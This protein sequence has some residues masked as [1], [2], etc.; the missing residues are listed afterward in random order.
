M[1]LLVFLF[2]SL[3]LCFS[4]G[5]VFYVEPSVP[6]SDSESPCD[7]YSPCHSLQYYANHSSFTTNNSKFLFLKG[8]HHLDTGVEIRYVANLSLVGTDRS[9]VKILCTSH[10]SGFH[11]EEF[12]MLTI[13]NISIQNCCVPGFCVPGFS[14]LS[15]LYL[16]NG[17][18]AI[19]DSVTVS[20]TPCIGLAAEDVVG[21]FVITNSIFN[22]EGLVRIKYGQCFQSSYLNFSNNELGCTGHCFPMTFWMGCYDVQILIT[23]SV[24]NSQSRLDVSGVMNNNSVLISNCI[25]RAPVS[26]EAHPSFVDK[27]RC[28]THPFFTFQ[29]AIVS[30]TLD[31]SSYAPM[32]NNVDPLLCKVLLVDSSQFQSISLSNDNTGRIEDMYVFRNVSGVNMTGP[33]L[34]LKN[35]AASLANCTFENNKKSAI[36]A[37]GS[38]VI[39]QGKN[40]FRNNSALAGAA[41]LV[42]FSGMLIEV[43][44]MDPEMV[45]EPN[46]QV[47]FE[48]NHADNLGGAIYVNIKKQAWPCFVSPLDSTNE[49][50]FINNS[51]GIAGSSIYANYEA[52]QNCCDRMNA[53]SCDTFLNVSNTETDPSAIASDPLEVCLCDDGKE[54]PN[55]SKEK[56]SVDIFPGQSFPIRLAVVSSP[57]A[58]VVPGLI[59]VDF[60]ASELQLSRSSSVSQKASCHNYTYHVHSKENVSFKLA[61]G[62]TFVTVVYDMPLQVLI[63][64]NFKACPIGFSFSNVTE[65]CVCDPVLDKSD[66]NCYIDTESIFRPAYSWIG[67]VNESS[68]ISSTPGVVFHPNC[69]I[70]YCSLRGTNIT[71][72]TRD[73]QCEPHRTGLLCGKCEEGYSLTLGNE[74]CAKCS[75]VYLLLI[76]PLAV[77]GVLLVLSLFALN[78]TVTEGRLNGLFFYANVIGMNRSVILSGGAGP[79]YVFLAWLNLDL[80]ITVCLFDGMDGYVVTW[81]QFVFPVYLWAIILVVTL[82]YNKFPTLATK[83]GG[84]NAEKVL[85]T[86]F[87]LSYTKLQ[88]TVVTIMS[89]TRLEYPDGVDRY[90]WLYD[91]NVEFFKGKHFY[92]GIAGILVLVFLIV[93]YTLCLVFFQQLQACSTHT[94]FQWVNKL[95]PVF[96][97]YAGPYKDNYR[98]WTGMLLLVRTLLIVLFTINSAASVDLNLLI[99]TTVAFALALAHSNGIYNKWRNNYLEAFFY[100]Q[101][102]VFAAGVLYARHNHGNIT[103]VADASFGL[104]L[105][106]FLAVLGY[107]GLLGI[108]KCYYRYKGYEDI[109]KEQELS[110]SI[111]HVRM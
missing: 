65:S 74:E 76:L 39:F 3:P 48:N 47:I 97:A 80:G 85:A 56:F 33:T 111:N 107:Y 64:V 89:F 12:I 16:K 53:H 103:A 24:F 61:S 110:D 72:N 50:R 58:G 10:P 91:A 93:P 7:G 6:A 71:S 46:A 109:D 73:S 18:E 87:L 54:T 14:D 28:S 36:T 29:D 82:L 88:R 35:V 100:V 75:N 11:F 104:S 37:I 62:T 92:L 77:L 52:I 25:I 26:V 27:I 84:K 59:H 42:D 101:L 57:Y 70:G 60:D 43:Y 66:V 55:C 90:V 78:L 95:K 67:F 81:L 79:L 106:V 51:A 22:A 102:G 23:G 30:S 31:I 68:P 17:S 1:L 96:D 83:L 44:R 13:R 63:G 98:F 5:N 108:Q 9:G 15:A 38:R 2:A 41:I 105:L 34:K 4:S 69:P 94:L 40:A 19:V 86:L 8:K 21:A 99:I 45:L 32:N 20:S 49:I